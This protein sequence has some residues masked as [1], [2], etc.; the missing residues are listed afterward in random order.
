M[1]RAAIWAASNW[2]PKW[3]GLWVRLWRTIRLGSDTPRGQHVRMDVSGD[4]PVA[5]AGGLETEPTSDTK[6]DVSVVEPVRRGG[7]GSHN[8]V[9]P[10]SRLGSAGWSTAAQQHI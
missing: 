10:R 3:D 5:W 8:D 2:G 6:R 4:P 7:K 9:V 1:P